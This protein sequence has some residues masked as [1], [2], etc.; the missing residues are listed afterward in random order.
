MQDYANQIAQMFVGW[1]ITIIDLPRLTDV[2]IGQIS[3]DLLSGDT[4]LDGRP[5]E[6]FNIGNVVRAWLDD[7]IERDSLTSGYVE[8]VQITCDFEVNDSVEDWGTRRTL[9]L[10]SSVVVEAN[11]QSWT[12]TSRK[13]E[14][15]EK[16]GEAPWLIH[17]A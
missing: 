6:P 1:Q 7:A 11:Q 8:G 17:D 5:C 12:G 14:V 4:Q 15:W 10:L 16:L 9:A 13:S 2:G 3:L